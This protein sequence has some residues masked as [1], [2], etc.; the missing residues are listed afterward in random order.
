MPSALACQISSTA[1]GIG[2]PAVV[3]TRPLTSVSSPLTVQP[4]RRS[5]SYSYCFAPCA[6][7]GPSTVASVAPGAVLWLSAQTIIDSPRMSES[8]MN[9][10]RLSSHFWPTAVM[11]LMPSNHSSSV[12]C[13]SRA[14]A[15]RCFTAA[16]MISLKRLS[17]VSFNRATTAAVSVSSLNWRMEL[18][19]GVR[20][21]SVLSNAAHAT[22]YVYSGKHPAKNRGADRGRSQGPGPAGG[23]R[24]RLPRRLAAAPQHAAHHRRGRG[25]ARHDQPAPEG[26][27]PGG[28]LQPRGS[29]APRADPRATADARLPLLRAAP[30][31]GLRGGGEAA[32]HAG[33][34][35]RGLVPAADLLP[36]EPLLGLRHRGGR[37]VARLLREARLRAR[38]RLLPRQARQGHPEG[39]R[40]RAH[41]RL[42]HLQ[43]LL[44]PRR[45]DEGDG[46]TARPRQGEGFRQRQRHGAVPRHRRRDRR[47]LPPRDGRARERGGMGPRQLA[48]HALEV[49]GL[50]RARL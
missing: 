44:R 45:A 20:G 40:A 25:G 30:A 48:R 47:S 33:A 29:E 35:P 27:E 36:P 5:P 18:L 24:P 13:T 8:R 15:C 49:R 31:A 46:R 32:R 3:S 4:S 22:R 23:L 12:R 42:H 10:W 17:L 28:E 7:N 16:V 19:L 43:R 39:A 38:V 6:K 50:H 1:F 37:A 11:N 9:S 26:D 21:P 34:H 41:L 14:N 2:L